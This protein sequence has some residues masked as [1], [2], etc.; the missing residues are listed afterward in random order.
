[1]TPEEIIKIEKRVRQQ[2]GRRDKKKIEAQKALDSALKKRL[3]AIR[4][5]EEKARQSEH[6]N[7]EYLARAEDAERR[8]KSAL[9]PTSVY[10]AGVKREGDTITVYVGAE[11][12]IDTAGVTF[13]L[14]DYT[15]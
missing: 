13:N 4:K 1:M 15:S 9:A 2:I 7:A 8:L 14:K 12:C 3:E 10:V 5:R 11:H 6:K